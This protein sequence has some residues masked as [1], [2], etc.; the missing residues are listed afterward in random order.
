MSDPDNE[1]GVG[2]VLK[3][4]PGSSDAQK[5]VLS[6][7]H[8][9][10][11]EASGLNAES[12]S[13]GGWYTERSAR[14]L[15]A[16]LNW[17]GW[18]KARGDGLVIPYFLPDASIDAE[19]F[20]ARVKPTNPRT[21]EKTKKPHR[22]EQ[23]KD[24]GVAPYFPVRTRVHR[25]LQDVAIPLVFTEGEKKGALLDQLGFAAIAAPGVRCFHDVAHRKDTDEYRLH[26]LIRKHAT[27][28]ARPCLIV[29]DADIVENDQVM[30]AARV[31]AGMLLAAGAA[32]VRLVM[33]PGSTSSQK[34]G[35]DD[36]F[37]AHGEQALRALIDTADPIEGI[38][39][40]E[41]ADYIVGYRVLEGIPL[42]PKLRMPHGYNIDRDGSLWH[43]DGKTPKLVERSAIFISRL[44][45]DLYSGHELVELVFRRDRSWRAVVMPRR[46]MVDSR[47]IV[48]ELAQ[49]G[50]PVDTNSAAG[51]ITWLRDFEAA[52]E[53]RLPRS[54]SVN[55][56]GWHTVSGE[57]V[58]VFGGEVV[59][60]E[61]S[62]VELVVD[63]QS[64][65]VRLTRGLGQTGERER[66]LEA[67]RRAWAASSLAAATIAAALAAPTLRALGAP[68]FALHLAGDSSRGKSSML[69]V[70]ASLY[71]NPKDEEWVAS[72]NSTT[73][74]H[75]QR[76]AHL[77]DLPLAI[78]EA[79]VVEAK[80][81]ERAVYMIMNGVG[82]T[83]GAKD[84]GLRETQSWRTVMLSTGER[85]LTEEESPTGAQVRVLQLQVSGFGTLDAAGVDE[86]RRLSEENYGH[87]GREWIEAW[88]EVTEDARIAHRASLKEFVR[89]F[90]ARAPD[91]LRA[92]QA[93]SWAL[94]AYVESVAHATLGLGQANGATMARLYAEPSDVHVRVRSAAD[95]GIE[96]LAHWMRSEPNAFQE[97]VVNP[98]ATVD[99]KEA[100]PT[101]EV[102][103]YI[104]RR[105]R[106]VRVLFLPL[107]LKA[108]LSKVAIDDGV[109]LR[110]WKAAGHLDTT[111]DD[112]LTAQVRIGGSRVRVV[113]MAGEPL[114]L[115]PE[116]VTGVTGYDGF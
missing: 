10:E 56:C 13:S 57:E 22:Y 107:A 53:R 6:L 45:V 99:A 24:V 96:Q 71:G 20:F 110:E 87:I 115:D 74:G 26:E 67:L 103:G 25:R 16:L 34:V 109:V 64:D 66:H 85:K 33:I 49:L 112:R 62:S 44:V 101:R 84:G 95:R 72:W 9:A 78:D 47:A 11:L 19:P 111:G 108:R 82:R 27:I 3:L 15:A 29:F 46:V 31:L 58:F 92:R 70:A 42:D 52:N 88:L 73:V 41:A 81:R 54:K 55:R 116:A 17:R 43:D 59:R 80:D 40:N 12:I 51:V 1:K 2:K 63:R 86:V 113:S 104:D 37:V 4:R 114:G 98:S 90:Q 106:G 28:T 23:P 8:S 14:D 36:F 77:C 79:G 21:D 65:R 102:A 94:L 68:I 39:G 105:G 89:Q 30:Q 83:R 61:G 75:E 97:L 50:A 91:P 76:A 48:G 60:R 69:K 5:R 35:V 93:L 18:P 100:G 38:S 32:S 7:E